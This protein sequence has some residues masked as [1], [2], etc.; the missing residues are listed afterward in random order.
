[1]KTRRKG[2]GTQKTASKRPPSKEVPKRK[3]EAKG[4]GVYPA[5]GPWP[6]S[7]APVRGM[8]EWGQGVRGAEGYEDHGESEAIP[9]PPEPETKSEDSEDADA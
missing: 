8:A 5:S 4:S 1:M 6:S 7:D 3:E 9:M 2:P